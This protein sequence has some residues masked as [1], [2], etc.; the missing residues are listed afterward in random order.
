M[1]FDQMPIEDFKRKE[2]EGQKN[3]SK[4]EELLAEAK[5]QL[6]LFE[7]FYQQAKE[8]KDEEDKELYRK[9]I[10]SIKELISELSK[11]LGDVNKFLN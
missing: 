6:E 1:K 9:E 8:E 4:I 7:S 10:V 2:E 3:L 5:D 11:K